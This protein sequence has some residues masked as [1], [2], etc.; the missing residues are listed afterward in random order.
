MKFHEKLL[1]LTR[2]KQLY[3]TLKVL[4]NLFEITKNKLHFKLMLTKHEL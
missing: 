3:C 2:S 4:N 1:K